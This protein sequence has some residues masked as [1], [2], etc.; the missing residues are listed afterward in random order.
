MTKD[1]VQKQN[2]K[3]MQNF[4]IFLRANYVVIN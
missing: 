1:W 4:K 2:K 3:N